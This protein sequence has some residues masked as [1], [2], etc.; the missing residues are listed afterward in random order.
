MAPTAVGATIMA[1][2]VAVTAGTV[3]VMGVVTVAVMGVVIA[4]TKAPA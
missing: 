1:G 4:T 3:A 2:T